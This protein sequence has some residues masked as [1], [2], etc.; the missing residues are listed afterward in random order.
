ME[1]KDYLNEFNVQIEKC[2]DLSQRV[3][4]YRLY[5]EYLKNSNKHINIKKVMFIKNIK[6]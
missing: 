1:K 2:N 5:I 6:F 4:M 3:L